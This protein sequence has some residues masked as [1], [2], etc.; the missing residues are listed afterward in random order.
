MMAQGF[1]KL[2][3]GIDVL[4]LKMA[5]E[6]QVGVFEGKPAVRLYGEGDWSGEFFA[7]PQLRQLLLDVM[8]R[9]ECG[10]LLDVALVKT[11]EVAPV[12]PLLDG[13]QS[14]VVLALS[15]FIVN[16]AGPQRSGDVL[17]ASGASPLIFRSPEG[18]GF[19]IVV[20]FA[21]IP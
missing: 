2:A 17:W 8:R 13:Q 16:S 21:P 1:I 10:V 11:E 7:F 4:P 9:V 18:G 14:F 3:E 19:A 6:R 15:D 12:G 5:V 20:T